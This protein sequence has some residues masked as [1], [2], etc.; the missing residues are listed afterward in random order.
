MVHV[1]PPKC[2]SL[3][4]NDRTCGFTKHQRILTLIGFRVCRYASSVSVVMLND[5]KKQQLDNVQ[6]RHHLLA[7]FIISSDKERIS[8]CMAEEAESSEAKNELKH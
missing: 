7:R 6:C 5:A 3:C 1:A 2:I 8:S 4:R